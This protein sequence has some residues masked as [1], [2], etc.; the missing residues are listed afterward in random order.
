MSEDR[1]LWAGKFGY[2]PDHPESWDNALIDKMLALRAEKGEPEMW[3]Q[4]HILV[5]PPPVTLEQLNRKLDKI[6]ELLKPSKDEF[7]RG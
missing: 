7:S 5:T 4:W 6:I 1:K 3:R 2:S